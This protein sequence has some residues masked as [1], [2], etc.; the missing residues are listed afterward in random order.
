MEFSL[1]WKDIQCLKHSTDLGPRES[2]LRRPPL[3]SFIGDTLTV[4]IIIS[5]DIFPLCKGVG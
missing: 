3:L 5:L 4:G 2:L 1:F